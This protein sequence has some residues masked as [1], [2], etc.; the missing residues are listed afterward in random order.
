MEHDLVGGSDA[1]C[2]SLYSST[3]RR[4]DITG[5]AEIRE[6]GQVETLIRNTGA[7]EDLNII[8]FS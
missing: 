2:R 1:A 7:A 8:D 4:R 6:E 3:A 5:D